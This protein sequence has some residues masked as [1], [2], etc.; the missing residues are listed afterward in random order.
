MEPDVTIQSSTRPKYGTITVP[1]K[2]YSKPSETATPTTFVEVRTYW[3]RWA[4]L[5]V[6]IL[7]QLFSNLLWITF[8]P[9]ADIMRCYY[10]VSNE[11]VNTLSL[12]SAVLALL[13]VIPA[14]WLLIRYGIRFVIVLSSFATALGGALRVMGAGSGYFY[15]L[16]IGQT[17]SSF[18]GLMSGASTLLSETWFPASERVTATALGASIAPQVSSLM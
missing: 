14:A 2:P 1:P 9:V 17:V 7:N 13:L 10:G 16:I 8:A 18:N 3:W 11:L 5:G 4:V 15:L 6:F 12:V